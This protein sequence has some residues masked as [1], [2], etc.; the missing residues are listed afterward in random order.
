VTVLNFISN[1]WDSIILVG[2]LIGG[3]LGITKK[4]TTEDDLWERLMAVARQHFPEILSYSDA[5]ARARGVLEDA[6]W[7]ALNRIGVKKTRRLDLVVDDVIDH[8][9]AELATK[10]ID[11][12]LGRIAASGQRTI[13]KID[14]LPSV[15]G[16][17]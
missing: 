16:T 11:R 13:E 17:P 4:K 7:K 9:L 12:D 2:G 3:W 6:V 5:H 10:L 1:N 8:A 15:S 14:T